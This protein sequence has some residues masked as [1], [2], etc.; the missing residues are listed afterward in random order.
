[1]NRRLCVRCHSTGY[2]TSESLKGLND[3]ASKYKDLSVEEIPIDLDWRVGDVEI[4]QAPDFA[5]VR[6][7]VICTIRKGQLRLTQLL[8]IN[9]S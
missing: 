3:G 4:L 2:Q 9:T 6:N 7:Q 8:P 5:Y 1:M